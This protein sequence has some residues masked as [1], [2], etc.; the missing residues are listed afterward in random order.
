MVVFCGG[1]GGSFCS[2]SSRNCISHV[3]VVVLLIIR[4]CLLYYL[5]CVLL[6]MLLLAISLLFAVDCTSMWIFMTMAVGVVGGVRY[7]TKV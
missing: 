3:C 4:V 2:S 1:Y 6:C 7:S 5:L